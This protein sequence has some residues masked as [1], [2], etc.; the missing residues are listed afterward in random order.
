M[1]S[2]HDLAVEY[3]NNNYNDQIA[4]NKGQVHYKQENM[5]LASCAFCRVID[6]NARSDK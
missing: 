5:T 3:Y 6:V 1:A 4:A 2:V